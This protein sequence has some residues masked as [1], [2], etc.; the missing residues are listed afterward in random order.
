MGD[1]VN[2][3]P[4]GWSRLLSALALKFDQH[5]ENTRAEAFV[6]PIFRAAPRCFLAGGSGSFCATMIERGFLG[7]GFIGK[8]RDVVS[9]NLVFHVA[10]ALTCLLLIYALLRLQSLVRFHGQLWQSLNPSRRAVQ[11]DWPSLFLEKFGQALDIIVQGPAEKGMAQKILVEVW[12][13]AHLDL[14]IEQIV[15]QSGHSLQLITRNQDQTGLWPEKLEKA[16]GGQIKVL[17]KAVGKEL[18]KGEKN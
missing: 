5:L 14:G 7:Q 2:R 1:S 8:G 15:W 17:L 16:L 13:R 3:E 4:R 12:V 11:L 10:S 6:Q 9:F 18:S